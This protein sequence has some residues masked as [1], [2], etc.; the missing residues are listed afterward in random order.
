MLIIDFIGMRLRSCLFS[1]IHSFKVCRPQ[2]NH[3]AKPYFLVPQSIPNGTNRESILTCFGLGLHVLVTAK[4]LNTIT[5]HSQVNQH[6]I[7]A[8]LILSNIDWFN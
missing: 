6:K 7:L 8:L 5:N 2:A 4:Y 1:T 3:S